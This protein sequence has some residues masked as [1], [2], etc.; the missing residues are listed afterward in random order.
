[1]TKL[2]AFAGF[3]AIRAIAETARHVDIKRFILLLPLQFPAG[4]PALPHP[5]DS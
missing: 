1:M 2:A 3:G 4:V 5:G